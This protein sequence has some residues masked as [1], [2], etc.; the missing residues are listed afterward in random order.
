MVASAMGESGVCAM[1]LSRGANLNET[2]Y[3]GETALHFALNYGHLKLAALLRDAD[4]I[5][6]VNR[7]IEACREVKRYDV[8]PDM[9]EKRDRLFRI[10]SR[11]EGTN[12]R[13]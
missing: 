7:H 6:V 12:L 9:I 1:L 11:L 2:N 10:I 3:F 13:Q 4:A 8:I 5:D